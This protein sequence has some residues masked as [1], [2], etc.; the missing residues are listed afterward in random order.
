[1]ASEFWNLAKTHQM[2]LIPNLM[3][4]VLLE[5]MEK[6]AIFNAKESTKVLLKLQNR[7]Y[8]MKAHRR[9]KLVLEWWDHLL[10]AISFAR[11]ESLD[12]VTDDLEL[13]SATQDTKVLI[14]RNAKIP[15]S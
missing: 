8:Y 1:M 9:V 15:T 7:N 13:V 2:V 4:A 14:V 5:D 10:M 12:I 11:P 3:K 6:P